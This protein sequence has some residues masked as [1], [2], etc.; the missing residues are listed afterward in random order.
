MLNA[1]AASTPGSPD[2]PTI[3]AIWFILVIALLTIGAAWY[4]ELVLGY[5]P[6]EL[7]LEQRIAY[8]AAIPLASLVLIGAARGMSL[9]VLR[10]ALVLLALIF[11]I[12]AGLGIY[13]SGVE[14]HF[15]PGPTGCSGKMVSGPGNAADLLNAMNHSKVVSC[16]DAAWRLFYISMAGWN[17]LISAG[18]AIIALKTLMR[19]PERGK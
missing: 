10:L 18:L 5:I 9:T 13:H 2:L 7:C 4:F 6:C 19:A 16:E 14:W 17:A 1:N 15:W 8:Y 11:L 12:N 3:R